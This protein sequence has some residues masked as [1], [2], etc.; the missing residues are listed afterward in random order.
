[1][2]LLK[3]LQRI[4]QNQKICLNLRK[5]I[6]ERIKKR[7]KRGQDVTRIDNKIVQIDREEQESPLLLLSPLPPPLSIKKKV[8]KRRK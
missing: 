2:S 4:S 8:D 3:L 1:M 7:K 5:T 6:G